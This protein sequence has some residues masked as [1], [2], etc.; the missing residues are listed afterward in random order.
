MAVTTGTPWDLALDQ[1]K[2]ARPLY[3]GRAIS[4]R[5]AYQRALY[6]RAVLVDLRTDD[7]RRSHGRFGPA[8]T[9]VTVPPRA[10][11]TWLVRRNTTGD[12]IVISQDGTQADD[13]TEALADVSLAQLTYVPG[14]VAAWRS[15]GLPLE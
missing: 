6:G 7:Q 10:L 14:G 1:G 8:L 11:V 5:A 9:A 15:A 3:S 2:H 4:A 13:V 12:V